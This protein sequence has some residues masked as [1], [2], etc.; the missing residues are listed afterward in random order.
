MSNSTQESSQVQTASDLLPILQGQL[1]RPGDTS[2]D[3]DRLVW[4]GMIDRRPKYIVRCS[5]V[6]DVVA[7]VNF[8]RNNNLLLS[9]RGGGTT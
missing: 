6:A 3:Q 5:S 2:Y 1:I 9:I 7:A 4:N 8:A